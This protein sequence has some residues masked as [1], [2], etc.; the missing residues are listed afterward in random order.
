MN[1]IASARE[2]EIVVVYHTARIAVAVA[3]KIVHHE[4]HDD[5]LCIHCGSI[6]LAEPEAVPN[7]V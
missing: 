7:L 3:D 4:I 1:P 2:L 6:A 5:I